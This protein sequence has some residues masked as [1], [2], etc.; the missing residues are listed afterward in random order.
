VPNGKTAVA[1]NVY[2]CQ[3]CQ[4]GSEDK[5]VN[6]LSTLSQDRRP[7]GHMDEQVELDNIRGK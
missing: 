2:G 4:R 3:E 1:D 5:H 7:G 6:G